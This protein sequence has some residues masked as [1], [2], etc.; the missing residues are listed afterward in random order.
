ML[1]VA[2]HALNQFT[3]FRVYLAKGIYVFHLATRPS[4][5]RTLTV[6]SDLHHCLRSRSSRIWPSIHNRVEISILSWIRLDDRCSTNSASLSGLCRNGQTNFVPTSRALSSIILDSGSLVHVGPHDHSLLLVVLSDVIRLILTPRSFGRLP[7]LWQN[8]ATVFIISATHH[9]TVSR[10]SILTASTNLA[11]SLKSH[12]Q[13]S[14]RIL[15]FISILLFRSHL[16][17]FHLIRAPTCTVSSRTRARAANSG[18]MA[19]GTSFVICSLPNNA[20]CWV[21]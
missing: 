20:S 9:W 7:F 16:N 1:A 5:D 19:V 8:L 2:L 6:G 4:V 11:V 13:R 12:C 10:L 17:Y 21:I 18:H 14:V 15:I 3:S